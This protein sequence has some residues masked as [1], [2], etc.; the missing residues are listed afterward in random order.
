MQAK[1]IDVC[2]LIILNGMKV[3]IVIQSVILGV[4]SDT[5]KV[6]QI[7]KKVLERFDRD[8]AK[9]AKAE[10]SNMIR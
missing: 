10:L 1:H 2:I 7:K 9:W 3:L 6:S 8:L 5:I 4:K